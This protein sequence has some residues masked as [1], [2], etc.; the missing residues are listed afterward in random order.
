MNDIDV[1]QE[2]VCSGRA[3]TER[4]LLACLGRRREQ[5]RQTSHWVGEGGFKQIEE[6][7]GP[8]RRRRHHYKEQGTSCISKSFL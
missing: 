6:A 2:K 4:Q 1:K 5:S 3:M 7:G 8:R